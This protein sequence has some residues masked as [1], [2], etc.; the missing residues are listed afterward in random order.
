[1]DWRNSRRVRETVFLCEIVR[2]RSEDRH[3]KE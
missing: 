2:E 3:R 1:V